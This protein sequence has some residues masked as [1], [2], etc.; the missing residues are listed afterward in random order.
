MTRYSRRGDC[1]SSRAVQDFCRRR[2]QTKL[3]Q[4]ALEPWG[5]RSRCASISH[6]RSIRLYIL[7][8]CIVSRQCADSYLSKLPR[9]HH[10]ISL[11]TATLHDSVLCLQKVL[12]YTIGTVRWLRR[13]R[14]R[15]PRE[16]GSGGCSVVGHKLVQTLRELGGL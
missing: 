9:T 13:L 10:Q 14:I 6:V 1:V 8:S 12:D 15:I 4:V 7:S 16:A 2:W 5:S 11:R 3:L